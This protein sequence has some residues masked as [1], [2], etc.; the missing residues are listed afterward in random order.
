MNS[1]LTLV[2]VVLLAFVMYAMGFRLVKRGSRRYTM[3]GSIQQPPVDSSATKQPDRTKILLDALDNRPFTEVITPSQREDLR[4]ALMGAL[5]PL[6][7]KPGSPVRDG[8][9]SRTGQMVA[10]T[11]V[12]AELRPR[13]KRTPRKPLVESIR[14]SW[15]PAVMM[16]YLGA[17]LVV[18]A[19]LIFATYNWG[20]LDGWQ[21]IGMLAALTV[22]FLLAGFVIRRVERLKPAATTFMTV[23]GLLVPANFLAAYTVFDDV[24]PAMPLLLG[25]IATTV[26]HALLSYQPNSSMFR[27]TTVGAAIVA[28]AA[29]PASVGF[30]AGWGGVVAL[31]LISLLPENL[32]AVARFNKAWLDVSGMAAIA[33]AGFALWRSWAHDGWLTATAL[34][35]IGMVATRFSRRYPPAHVPLLAVADFALIAASV[36]FARSI[37]GDRWMIAAGLM[38][39]TLVLLQESRRFAA[40]ANWFELAAAFAAAA[41]AAEVTRVLAP[42]SWMIMAGMAA[43]TILMLVHAG[44]HTSLNLL[45]GTIATMTAAVFMGELVRNVADGEWGISA[46]AAMLATTTILH[47]RR[48]PHYAPVSEAVSAFAAPAAVATGILALNGSD[49]SAPVGLGLLA[50]TLILYGMRNRILGDGPYAV[51]SI[52]GIVAM[53]WAGSILDIVDDN[54]RLSTLLLLIAL[55][56]TGI[57]NFVLIRFTATSGW[58]KSLLRIEAL[59]LFFLALAARDFEY[60]PTIG[61]IAF[62][63]FWNLWVTRNAAWSLPLSGAIALGWIS[64]LMPHGLDADTSIW[65]IIGLGAVFAV[66][67]WQL[68]RRTVKSGDN[69]FTAG[70]YAW[71]PMTLVAAAAIAF[72]RQEWL[73]D[74]AGLEHGIAMLAQAALFYVAYNST[75][76]RMWLVAAGVFAVFASIILLFGDVSASQHAIIG[77]VLLALAV[78]AFVGTSRAR[79]WIGFV[80]GFTGL[81]HIQFATSFDF[82]GELLMGLAAAWLLVSLGVVRWRA[83]ANQRSAKIIFRQAMIAH[84]FAWLTPML[85]SPD[86]S[87]TRPDLVI[88]LISLAGVVATYGALRRRREI[89]LI[90]SAIGMAGLMLQ[91]NIGSPGNIHAYTVPLSIYLIAVGLMLR[92]DARVANVMLAAGSGMLVIPAMIEA[93]TTGSINWLWIA[94]AESI[95]L[96]LFGAVLRLRIPSAA[97]VIAVTV[98]ALRMLVLVVNALASW[99]SI[100]AIGMMLLLIGTFWLI[101]RDAI[102]ARSHRLLSRW[103]SFA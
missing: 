82:T 49:W 89:V 70:I 102:T 71:L 84:A 67:A 88:V 37:D 23:G 38:A 61:V 92:R 73:Q 76:Q 17:L 94:L 20:S 91:I 32:R 43:L 8:V 90:G 42:D 36:Q 69:A 101:F 93:L 83:E 6:A 35:A 33:L 16:L 58:L 50:L 97:G 15:D 75:R 95:A 87:I 41:L 68:D 53:V 12:P 78:V 51:A 31:V 47:A 45:S 80:A 4:I 34:V 9:D 24:Q 74:G 48:W 52:V 99:I 14:S 59:P 55:A 30:N 27:Y 63:L 54:A 22:A 1:D 60:A 11:S 65:W 19:G 2:V 28:V 72:T 10:P 57:A 103:R 98:I 86:D 13:R 46:F 85:T 77:V 21:K 81:V 5:S 64:I 7:A 96:F 25:A 39:L 56:L 62:A 100:L 79:L 44:R 66:F 3:P 18:I 29:V 40:L 26:V